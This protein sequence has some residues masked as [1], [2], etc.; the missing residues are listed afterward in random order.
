MSVTRRLNVAGRAG[1]EWPVRRQP[2]YGRPRNGS[3]GLLSDLFSLRLQPILK[4]HG[5]LMALSEACVA[6]K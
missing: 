6:G 2:H 1:S 4:N 5:L 3:S